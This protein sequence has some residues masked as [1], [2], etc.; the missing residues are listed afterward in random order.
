MQSVPHLNVNSEE[1]PL[2]HS[3]L[4]R[5]APKHDFNQFLSGLECEDLKSMGPLNCLYSVQHGRQLCDTLCPVVCSSS[6]PIQG[7]W[8]L[9]CCSLCLHSIGESP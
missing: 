1:R 2:R 4:G 6:L 7:G 9:R 8:L 3:S 5:A